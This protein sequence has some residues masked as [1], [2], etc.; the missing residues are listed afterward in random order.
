M[1]KNEKPQFKQTRTLQTILRVN[2][3]I[4]AL[5]LRGSTHRPLF[6]EE[7]AELET[8]TWVIKMLTAKKSED[9][10]DRPEGHK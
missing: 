2:R 9:F 3:R 7:Q 6:E 4:A 5:K 10:T 1:K 8:L